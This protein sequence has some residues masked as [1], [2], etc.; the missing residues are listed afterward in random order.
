MKLYDYFR[1]STAYRIRIALNLKGLDAEKIPVNLL[2]GAQKADD[3]KKL[4]PMASVPTLID[5]GHTLTQSM[6]ILEYLE[7][8]HPTPPLLPKTPH[9]RARARAMANLVA[10]DIHPLNNLRVLK[11][12]TGELGISEEQ[13]MTW[14]RHWIANG[15]TALETLLT[16]TPGIGTFCHGDTPTFADICLI[17]QVYNANRFECDMIPFPTITRINE[18]CQKLDAFKKAHPDTK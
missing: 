8:I 7:E 16:T 12:L 14:Y 2:E 1:S 15:F 4:N 5:D 13:K 6:A 9:E 11:Y 18:E 10:I 17:P 3:Y